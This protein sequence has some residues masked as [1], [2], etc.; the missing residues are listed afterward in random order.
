MD[1]AG[2]AFTVILLVAVAVHPLR[3]VT[4]TTYKAEGTGGYKDKVADVAPPVLLLQ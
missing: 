3:L 2:R 4:V 1:T